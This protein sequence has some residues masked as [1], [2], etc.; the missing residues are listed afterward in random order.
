MFSDDLYAGMARNFLRNRWLLI[1][2]FG[3]SPSIDASYYSELCQ[4]IS[5][6]ECCCPE[7]CNPTV[8]YEKYAVSLRVSRFGYSRVPEGNSMLMY[9]SLNDY[10]SGIRKL[11]NDHICIRKVSSTPPFV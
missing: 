1:Y 3:A 9:N 8:S 6:V 4:E 5:R 10:T 7:Y 11:V 2:L